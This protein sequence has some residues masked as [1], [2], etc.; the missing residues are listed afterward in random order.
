[1][2]CYGGGI[3]GQSFILYDLK[4][5]TIQDARSK[6]GNSKAVFTSVKP[7]AYVL[8]PN[9]TIQRGKE[10]GFPPLDELDRASITLF[11]FNSEY[12]V[13][14]RKGYKTTV[15][16]PVSCLSIEWAGKTPVS[17]TPR[18][19]DGKVQTYSMFIN[20]KQI[21]PLD[22]RD[23]MCVHAANVHLSVAPMNCGFIRKFTYPLIPLNLKWGIHSRVVLTTPA[24]ASFSDEAL[25]DNVRIEDSSGGLVCEPNLGTYNTRLFDIFPGEYVLRSKRGRSK[26]F[27]PQGVVTEIKSPSPSS[28]RTPRR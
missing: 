21:N 1:M 7:G 19:S 13:E 16:V 22:S 9:T 26:L 10:T 25:N 6:E 11:G 3:T 17:I 23:K 5:T 14:V 27:L 15:R 2:R 12:K 8:S 24:S 4:G 18:T 20:G 28:S